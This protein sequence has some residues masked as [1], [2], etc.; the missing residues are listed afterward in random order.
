MTDKNTAAANGA[1]AEKDGAYKW[2][3]LLVVVVGTF[4]AILDTSIVN[5]AIPKMMNVF[6]VS[7]D[8]IQ[9]VLTAYMLTM[10]AVIP[11][12]GFLGDTFGTKKTYIWAMVAFTVGSALCGFSWSSSTMI[13]ARVVQ[14]LGGGMIMPVSMAIIYQVIPPNERGVALGVWGIAAMAAPAIGPTLSG[15]IV[16]HLDWRLIFTINIPVGVVGVI[17]AALVLKESPKKPPKTFDY[18]GFLSSAAGLVAIL[19]VVGEG[20]NIDWNDPKTVMLLVFGIFSLIL[21]IANELT[22]QDPLLDL[23]VLKIFPFSLSI[24]ISS[25]T[26]IALFGGVFL[27]PLFLQN[28]QGYTAMQSGMIMFPGAIATGLMMPF[29]GKLFDK[30]GAKP[31]VIP[32]LLIILFSTYELSM[33]TMDTSAETIKWLIAVRG[34]GL[35]LA[36]MP[37]TTAGMNAVPPQLV[38]RAS[39]L[40]NV[41]RQ[42]ASSMGIAVLTTVMSNR[43]AVNYTRLAEKVTSFHAGSS[44]LFKYLNA[45]FGTLGISASEVQ[46][47]STTTMYGIV[48]KQAAAQAIN[49]T[50]FVT[51]VLIIFIIPLV[52]LMRGKK[53]TQQPGAEAHHVMME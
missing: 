31:V 47:L 20:S 39:A 3:A 9:W 5:I 22:H 17:L 50:F 15:Y 38:A 11:L 10:G 7:T 36:M 19:Y 14:A 28:L 29:S 49:D 25:I 40:Q 26:N 13:G 4:M 43:Q 48:A 30:F 1:A 46:G 8:Q 16:E 2:L 27:I 37:I 52:M 42:V 24:I 53:P 21:F 32:G 44:D 45:Y 33:L 51:V 12:T 34:F 6:G 18:I 23:R 35:G 41:I